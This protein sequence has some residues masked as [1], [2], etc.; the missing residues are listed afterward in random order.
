MG[1]SKNRA[2][3]TFRL[4]DDARDRQY[5]GILSFNTSNLPDDAVINSATLRIKKQ[6]RVGAN[7]FTT[8]GDILVDIRSGAFGKPTVQLE[9]FAS[10]ASM[11]AVANILKPVSSG[12]TSVALPDTAYPHI[13]LVGITQFRLRFA[14]EDND[15]GGADFLKFFS[16]D[17]STPSARPQLIIDYTLP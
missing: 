3:A 8:H 15:D 13:N 5:R 12:W 1:G 14:T 9:D 17:Y 11:D 4:G 7:P 6:G 16:G 2:A 10:A